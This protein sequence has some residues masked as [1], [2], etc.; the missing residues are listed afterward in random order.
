MTT[1]R[2][3]AEVSCQGNSE[4]GNILI[5][6]GMNRLLEYL[7]ES[8]WFNPFPTGYPAHR[9]SERGGW[10]YQWM[11]F[12]QSSAQI[13]RHKRQSNGIDMEL[14]ILKDEDRCLKLAKDLNGEIHPDSPPCDPKTGKKI[15]YL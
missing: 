15:G 2:R 10:H 5:E 6:I 9:I 7:D 11:I 13:F 12:S 14:F 3:N 4:T 8:G 1:L